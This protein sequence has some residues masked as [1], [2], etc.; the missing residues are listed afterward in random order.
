MFV[1]WGCSASATWTSLGPSHSTYNQKV[2][3]LAFVSL[4]VCM[5]CGVVCNS[6]KTGNRKCALPK[7]WAV[8]G[9]GASGLVPQEVRSKYKWS[10]TPTQ[11]GEFGA[12]PSV[13]LKATYKLHGDR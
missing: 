1:A 5:L 8:G 13:D 10:V 4:L 12:Q 11:L 2:N 3:I 7:V 6:N 9:G